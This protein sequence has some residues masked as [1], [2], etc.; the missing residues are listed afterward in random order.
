MDSET[1]ISIVSTDGLLDRRATPGL[2]VQRLIANHLAFNLSDLSPHERGPKNCPSY[3]DNE[4]DIRWVAGPLVF[5]KRCLTNLSAGG[6]NSPAR[7]A[8]RTPALIAL[9]TAFPGP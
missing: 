4:L 5:R 8:G 6:R 3:Y 2:N 7:P 9:T 1:G